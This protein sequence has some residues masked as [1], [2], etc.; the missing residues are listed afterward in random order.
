M[1]HMARRLNRWKAVAPHLYLAACLLSLWPLRVH[2]AHPFPVSLKGYDNSTITASSTLPYSPALSCTNRN[3]NLNCH[4]YVTISN[5]YHFQQGRTNLSGTITVSD[6]FDLIRSWILSFGGFGKWW[7]LSPDLAQ[8]A[9]K[10]NPTTGSSDDA[11][12]SQIDLTAMGWVQQCGGCHPGG[13]PAE[14]D[15]DGRFYSLFSQGVWGTMGNGG[16]AADNTLSYYV[17]TGRPTSGVSGDYAF[18]ARNPVAKAAARWDRTGVAEADCLMCHLPDYDWASR[19]AVLGGGPV[20][21]GA[22][23]FASAATA[24][25]G[26]ATVTLTPTPVGHAP[27]A[28]TLTID[29]RK[30]SVNGPDNVWRNVVKEVPDD[31]C[32]NCHAT[33]EFRKIGRSWQ[34]ETDIHKNRG[35]TCVRCHPAGRA[36]T[37]PRINTK[38][39]HEI[40]KGISLTGSVRDDLDGTMNGCKACHVDSK[41]SSAPNPSTAHRAIPSLHFDKL[42]C[43]ACHIPYVDNATTAPNDEVP[44]LVVDSAADGYGVVLPANRFLSN[45]PMTPKGTLSGVPATRWYPG[46]APDPADGGLIKTVRPL[47]SVRWALWN[48]VS[49]SGRVIRPVIQRN[50]RKAVGSGQTTDNT[51]I[52]ADRTIL[53]TTKNA[54]GTVFYRYINTLLYAALTDADGDGVREV[55]TPVEIIAFIDAITAA[56]D[57]FGQPVVPAG[58]QLVLLKGGKATYKTGTTTVASFDTPEADRSVFSLSHNVAPA[59]RALGVGGCEDCHGA[60]SAFFFRKE[61]LDPYGEDDKPTYRNAWETMGYTQGRVDELTQGV[62]TASPGPKGAS[63]CFIATAAYGS[64][65]EAHVATLRAFRERFLMGNAPGRLFVKG[66]YAA[67]PPIARFIAG[68]ETLKALVR[69]LLAPVVAVVSILMG[70]AG[71]AAVAA[72]LLSLLMGA[73]GWHV[74]RRRRQVAG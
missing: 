48:G 22:P 1:P 64:P 42:A 23:A 71:L 60:Q 68:S 49:G 57:D 26:W 51:T 21:P 30:N 73:Y 34:A 55:N 11:A 65:F 6:T 38:D 74:L 18:T 24:G 46:L 39:L 33:P 58:W 16:S 37:D 43:P 17:A 72:V 36:A 47:T 32:R 29:Y 10:V 44:D 15:R 53:Y 19:A 45:N 63:E 69:V 28:A 31:N 27:E 2:A 70:E 13:G 59:V 8:L 4:S 61:L 7:P 12:F 66:Y 35:M 52:P 20:V 56:T 3:G 5:G 67:S 54:A 25:A 41:D 14:Y 62:P 50:I 40:A 9:K